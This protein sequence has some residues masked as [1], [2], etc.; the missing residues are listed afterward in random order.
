MSGDALAAT[1]IADPNDSLLGW[2]LQTELS[3]NQRFKDITMF[4]QSDMSADELELIDRFYG[5]FLSRQLA[6]GA[7]LDTLLDNTPYLAVTT[8][9]SRAAR[10]VDPESFFAEYIGGLELHPTPEWVDT[11][12][13]KTLDLLVQVGLWVPEDTQPTLRCWRCMPG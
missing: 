7:Q 3:L 4:A 13:Q 8:L 6:A 12:Q 5:T 9:V 1:P 11:V 10:M 2:T